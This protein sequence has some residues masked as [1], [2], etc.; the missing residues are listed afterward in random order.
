METRTPLVVRFMPEFARH[1]PVILDSSAIVT[2]KECLRK[3]FYKYVLGFVERQAPIFFS[4]G[5]AYHKF[6][7]VMVNQYGKV[8]VNELYKI[9][10]T[11]AV[12][13]FTSD[14]RTGLFTQETKWDFLTV[15]RL[16]ISCK[17]AYNFFLKERSQKQ[18]EIIAVEQIL[19]CMLPDGEMIGGRADQIVRWSGRVWGRDHKTTSKDFIFYDRTLEPND[20]FTRY[21]YIESKTS[22]EII[23]GQMVLVMRNSKKKEG[24]P[25][26]RQFLAS[27]TQWQLE[28]WEREQLHWNKILQ[29]CRE[30]DTWPQEEKNCGWCEYRLVCCKPNEAAAASALKS[31]FTVKPWDFQAH[32]EGNE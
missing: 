14:I 30:N 24:G 32:A 1:E 28:Q 29:V 22:G 13:R 18:V 11:A 7:E 10:L 31:Q 12:N 20:Q 16:A 4:F 2:S 19:N 15:D 8:D 23:P 3:Y 27:R 21:T 26:I 9:A 17:V 5:S 25:E 6:W